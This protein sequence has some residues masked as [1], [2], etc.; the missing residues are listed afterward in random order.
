MIDESFEIHQS[1]E[2]VELDEIEK[3]TPAEKENKKIGN[4]MTRI[5]RQ[6][7]SSSQSNQLAMLQQEAL[8]SKIKMNNA[9]TTFYD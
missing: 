8:K 4:N 3:N 1:N 7:K 6:G 9:K 5:R 2:S